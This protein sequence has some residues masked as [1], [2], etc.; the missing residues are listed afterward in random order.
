MNYP[1][2]T[3]GGQMLAGIVVFGL[4]ASG[5]MIGVA[6]VLGYKSETRVD[7]RC[8]SLSMDIQ[9]LNQCETA[10]RCFYTYQDLEE[11]VH[12]YV[13]CVQDEVKK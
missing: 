6:A 11:L 4:I 12:G 7:A 9:V 1:V 13:A 8:K 5:T 2:L 3:K 10:S